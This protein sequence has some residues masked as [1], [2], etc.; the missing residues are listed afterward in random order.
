MSKRVKIVLR[1]LLPLAFGIFLLWLLYRNMD[2]SA[3]VETL[4]SDANYWII[5]GSCLFGT[6]GNTIRGLRWQLLNKSLPEGHHSRTIY[7]VLTTHGNYTVNMALPRLGEVWRCTAMKHYSGIGFSKLFGTLLVDRGMDVVV[8]VLLVLVAGVAN[9]D[10]F[11]NFFHENPD[12]LLSIKRLA[13]TPW[14]YLILVGV[15]VI[16]VVGWRFLRSRPLGHR[17]K[18]GF[19]NIGTGLRT[20]GRMDEKW[21]FYL[22]TIAIWVCYFLQFYTTFFAFSFTSHLGPNVG[23]L[24]FLMTAIAVAAPVQAGMGA[25]HFMVI[26]SLMVFGVNQVDA[27]SFALIVH[28]LQTLWVTL[29]GLLAIALLPIVGRKNNH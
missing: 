16:P 10:F 23:L 13:S 14:F 7:S 11:Q 19:S 15:V 8:T 25:W 5:L 2:F 27:S 20:I 18:E 17:I 29:V 6:V 3:L 12:L 24:T 22:Y 4:R 1:V 9:I 26:Y 21:L 28:T